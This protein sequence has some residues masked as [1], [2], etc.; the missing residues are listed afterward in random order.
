MT[1]TYNFEIEDGGFTIRIPLIIIE[2]Y[3]YGLFLKN[4]KK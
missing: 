2:A 4:K 3:L 1:Q